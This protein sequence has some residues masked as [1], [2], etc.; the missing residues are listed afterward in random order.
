MDAAVEHH[1]GVL[2]I[3]DA[4][5]FGAREP[6]K[7]NLARLASSTP[8]RAPF[9]SKKPASRF[10]GRAAGRGYGRLAPEQA[11]PSSSIASATGTYRPP[12]TGATVTEAAVAKAAGGHMTVR[13]QTCPSA[14]FPLAPRGPST[15]EFLDTGNSQALRG[16]A[17]HL[18]DHPPLAVADRAHRQ[19]RLTQERH[20]G[21]LGLR[22]HFGEGHGF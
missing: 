2:A 12:A 7:G 11:H 20:P 22:L 5:R 21:K 13:D 17:R 6:R 8:W 3:A 15:H 19:A 18:A 16:D 14:L 4:E 10:P 9:A 1:R